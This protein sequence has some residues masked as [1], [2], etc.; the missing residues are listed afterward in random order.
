[1]KSI[2]ILPL[3]AVLALPGCDGHGEWLRSQAAA[4]AYAAPLAGDTTVVT[5]RRVWSSP[6]NAEQ[7]IG[8]H[9]ST[10]MPSGTGLATLDWVTGDPGILDLVSRDFHRFRFNDQPYDT[11]TS[12]DP[13]VSPDGGQI[14]FLWFDFN[15]P[16]PSLLVVDVATG[17][18]RTIMTADPVSVNSIWPLAWTPAGD[19]VFAYTHPHDQRAGAVEVLLIPAAGGTPR[20]VH[21]ILPGRMGRGRTSVSPD[22]RWILYAHEL[23]R[24]QQRRSDIYIVDVRG[25]GARP[26]V[27]HAAL[28]QPVGWLPGADIVLF[29][30]D[31]S[32]TTDLWSVRVVNGRAIGEPRLVRSGFFR[33]EA[34]GFGGGGFF[35]AGGNGLQG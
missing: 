34:V 12:L 5:T 10:I 20:L 19:S 8:V 29:S 9:S 4:T 23:S 35:Y 27:E 33:S 7:R 1:M 31:R 21:T 16:D 28:D 6:P 15:K 24:G 25:G 13:V 22:G 3:L 14:T 2:R 17:E 18:S 26:L 30:S 11:G 32:G